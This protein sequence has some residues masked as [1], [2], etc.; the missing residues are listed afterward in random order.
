MAKATKIKEITL[1]TILWNCR[2]AL[3]GIGS[4]EKNRDAVIGLVFL[5]FAGDKFARRRAELLDQYGDIPDFLEK[6]SFYNAVNVFYI[7]E[8]SRWSH[9]VKYASAD[10]IAVIIDT[11]MA[12]IE[13]SNP[14]LKGALPQNLFSTLGASKESI[15]ALIDEINK[16]DEKRFHEEDL[17]GRVYE[18]FLQIY[19][20][21]GTKDDGE[22]YTPACI[23]ELIAEIIEPYSGIVYDPCCGSG[24]MFVQSLKFVDEHNGNRQNVSIVGQESKQDTWRLCKMN[25]AIRGISHNLGE[26]NASSFT[27]DLHLDKKVDY[28]MANPPFN[29]KG[30]RSEDQLTND[31][32]F[33]GFTLPPVANANYAWILHMLSKLDVTKGIAGFLLA[34]GALNS[35]GNEYE[36]R[37]ELLERDKIEAI[38]V[39]PRNMFYTTDISVTLWIMNMNKQA[40]VVNGRQLRDRKNEILFMDLRNWDSNVEEYVI[41][42]GKKKKKTVLT[43]AQIAQIKKIYNNWKSA[44]TTLYSDVPEFCKAVTLEGDNGIRAKNYSLAPSKYIEFIDNDLNIDYEKEMDRIQREMKEIIK[45]EKESQTKLID[46][47]RGIGYGI[48]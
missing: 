46:A 19:A 16:I 1:E 27:E 15:K 17:I 34:N 22:F 4:T 3:R 10:D 45:T 29:L 30:W 12:D 9:I 28:I 41:D 36:I 47:F 13:A 48:D 38:I 20:A 39:L 31:P 24:G 26:K 43:D 2:V 44:D 23:V 37:K 32:R 5:K 11:A 40:K 21:S 6:V 35:E 8:K 25:L 33:N 14:P 18:Y 7:G 42:K